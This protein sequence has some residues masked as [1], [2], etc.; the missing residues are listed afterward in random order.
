MLLLW[1]SWAQPWWMSNAGCS[2]E[3]RGIGTSDGAPN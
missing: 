3:S 1:S 2:F